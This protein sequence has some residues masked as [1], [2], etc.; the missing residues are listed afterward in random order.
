MGSTMRIEKDMLGEKEIPDDKYY[1][2][3]TQRAL[4][5]FGPA[6]EAIDPVF[7]K[8]YL[9]VK[10]AACLTNIEIK[11]LDEERGRAIITAIDALL[12]SAEPSQIC[13][14]PLSGGAGTSI[15]MNVNE[16]IANRALELAGRKKGDY[17]FISPLDH[18]NMHQ[19]TNDTFPTALRVAMMLRLKALENA[20]ISLQE[21]LQA[22]EK[23]F[24]DVVRLA[25][26]EL[27]DA[28]PTTVGMQF[29]AYAEAI[30]RDRWRIFKSEE[31]IK[32]VN[33]G[34]TAIGTGFG[35]PQEY[36]FKAWQHLKALTGL[37]LTRAENLV[38]ATQNFDQIIE[39]MAMVK[40]LAV[41]IM[42]ISGDIRLSASGPEGGLGEF[43]LPALQ[44][45]SSIMAGKVNPVIAEF[46][47]QSSL[48]VIANDSAIA[49]AAG[50][51]NLDLNQYAPLIAHL[52]MKNLSLMETSV[53]LLDHKLVR[54]IKLNRDRINFNL[55]GSLAILTY[56]SLIIGHDR[57][58]ETAL[59]MKETGKSAREILDGSGLLSGQKYDELVRPENIRMLGLKTRP[60]GDLST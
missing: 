9:F 58:S 15:N 35:A 31:R 60:R 50:L 5:N 22:R 46:C 40:A 1:G 32:T 2:I 41:N 45:G 33:L 56:L 30:G 53:S 54:G 39:V 16:V 4:E 11:T 14:N 48:Q 18:V 24:S 57:A 25:R 27:M 42:K 8:G 44:E 19:S 17:V 20:L 52:S 59:K 55:H 3:H 34:G 6:I 47:A 10:K 36:I 49:T 23:E 12:A 28:L 38:D 37:S 21:S 7:I 13:V 51:G 43:I 26:T 29:S